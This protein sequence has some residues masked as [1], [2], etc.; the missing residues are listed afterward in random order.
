M[1][2][3]VFMGNRHPLSLA[4]CEWLSGDG[5]EVVWNTNDG[6]RLP[7]EGVL[8]RLKPDVGVSVLY[9]HILSP[10]VISAFP[11]GIVN[12]HPSLLPY[13]RGVHPVFWAV[14]DGLP[15]GVTLH[16]IDEGVDT[17][18]IVAQKHV[19]YTDDDVCRDI[20]NRCMQEGYWLVVRHWRDVADGCAR[21]VA[22]SHR[23]ATLHR[24]NE[25][26]DSES[27]F[28]MTVRQIRHECKKR[29]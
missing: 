16:Y 5:D 19:E 26:P 1:S 4:V 25:L 6:R 10:A 24:R 8:R 29:R 15:A 28:D 21:R 22:Q 14:V 20:Y 18:D 12:L 3:I 13:N 11:R 23:K 17:G 7:S 9:T 2:R 27:W